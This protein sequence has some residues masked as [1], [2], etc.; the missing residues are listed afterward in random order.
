V[1]TSLK[2]SEGQVKQVQLLGIDGNLPF[3]QD[4]SGLKVTLP[5]KKPCQFAYTLKITY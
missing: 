4:Q 1:I 3:V 5:G 2:S